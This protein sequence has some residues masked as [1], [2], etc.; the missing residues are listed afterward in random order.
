MS[1]VGG[2][3]ALPRP[4]DRDELAMDSRRIRVTV[5][6]EPALYRRLLAEKSRRRVYRLQYSLQA[7][8]VELLDKQLSTEDD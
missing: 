7:I 6:L 2:V 8:I 3:M 5:D 1:V 4:Q